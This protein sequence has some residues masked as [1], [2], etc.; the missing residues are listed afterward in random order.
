MLTYCLECNENAKNIDAKM[1]KT[2]N[3]RLMIS[4]KRAVCGRKKSEFIKEQEAEELLSNL[5][6]TIPLNK[7]YY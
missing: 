2:K 7:G 6:I 1:M 3:G 4:S 5:G